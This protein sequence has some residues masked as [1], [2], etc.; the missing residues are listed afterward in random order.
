MVQL[1][2]RGERLGPVPGGI[3]AVLFDK[4]GT[5][6]HSE[7]MLL[8]LAEARVRH[9]LQLVDDQLQAD[10]HHQL[11]DL[12]RRAYGLEEEGVHPAGTTAVAARDHNLI[13]TATSLSQMGL[14]WPEALA[15][16]EAVFAQTDALH[17][18]SGPR[19]PQPTEGLAE[20]LDAL[21]EADVRCAVISNDDERGI[22]G[23]LRRHGFERHVQGLWSA[24][25]HPRKPDPGAVHGLCAA[26]AVDPARCVL[27]GDANSDLRMGRRAGLAL[28]LGYRAGW[29]RPVPLDPSFP[30]I[31][32]WRE[33]SL[34]V[35][36][37]PDPGPGP[38][39]CPD[40]DV[41]AATWDRT[42]RE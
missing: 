1:R 5:M 24:G 26:L 17:G 14:G 27:I 22:R 11:E 30:Q 23:F 37:G 31:D 9:C 20:L 39:P 2:L 8:A 7:P 21:L 34:A 18:D 38:D 16:A 29:R 33:L 42:A 4:D 32:H 19:P 28:V 6:S 15:I 36:A 35:D 40:P 10:R 13:S 25:H 41:A 12:L 3:A